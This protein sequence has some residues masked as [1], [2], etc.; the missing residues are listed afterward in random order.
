MAARA[1]P[2][3]SQLGALERKRPCTSMSSPHYIPRH[4]SGVVQERE[5]VRKERVVREKVAAATFARG[6]L[7]GVVDAAIDALWKR[8]HFFDPVQRAVDEARPLPQFALDVF[9]CVL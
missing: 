7:T 6:F 8:G 3:A 5:R 1:V 2:K 9:A 4:S